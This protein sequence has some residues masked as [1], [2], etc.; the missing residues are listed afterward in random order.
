MGS[1]NEGE[2]APPKVT[3]IYNQ[4]FAFYWVDDD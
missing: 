4:G 3:Q 1:D 2:L